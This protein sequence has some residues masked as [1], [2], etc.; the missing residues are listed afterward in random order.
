MKYPTYKFPKESRHD[1]GQAI[2]E[3]LTTRMNLVILAM[4]VQSWHTHFVTAATTHDVSDVVKCAK[5]AV[6]WKLRLDRPIW[7]T[8]FDKRFCFD[9]QLVRKRIDYVERHNVR[10]HLPRRPWQFIRDWREP[11]PSSFSPR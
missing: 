8:D 7:A 1:V 4:C 5:D 6:R 11:T 9:T 3:S 2:G 10:D